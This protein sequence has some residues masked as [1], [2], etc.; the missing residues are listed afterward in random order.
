MVFG[1]AA[2]LVVNLVMVVAP[3][4]PVCIFFMLSVVTGRLNL[5]HVDQ[6]PATDT[7]V[8]AVGVGDAWLAVAHEASR[9]V[10][11]SVLGAAASPH[12][13]LAT[14]SRHIERIGAVCCAADPL[15]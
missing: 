7:Q 9:G 5:V 13:M 15:H 4:L 2:C 1:E 12:V 6:V 10:A 3:L 8:L 14:R 11:K